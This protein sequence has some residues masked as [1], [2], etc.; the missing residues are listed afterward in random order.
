[1]RLAG[2]LGRLVFVAQAVAAVRVLARMAA[3]ARGVRIETTGVVPVERVSVLVPVLDEEARLPGCLEHLIASE[4]EV[5]EI[6]VVDGGSRDRTSEIAAA[7][8]LRDPRVRY[9]SAAPVADG[10][11]GKAWNLASGL[12]ESDAGSTWILTIDADV[13]IDARLA[14]SLVAHASR[15]GDD[16]MSVATMQQLAGPIDALVHPAFLATLVYRFGLPGV[17][18]HS[19]ASVQANGQCFFGR[20]SALEGSDAFGHARAS[21]CEDVT[22]ARRL[23]A[24]GYAVGFYESAGLATVRMYDDW[25]ALVANWPRSLPMRD[26]YTRTSS[27]VLL[28]EIALVLALPPAIVALFGKTRH[29]REMPLFKLNGILMLIR[30]ATLIGTRRAYCRPAATYWLAPLADFPAVVLLIVSVFRRKH[31]WRGRTLVEAA[32]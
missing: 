30:I 26:R 18:A 8:A 23:F 14:R 2:V 13:R 24:C 29:G 32:G 15:T 1:V 16:A 6:L 31:F 12:V 3:T 11:N 4:A 7:F 19:L 21:R 25:R 28:I 10:W 5:T 9:L 20:R 27:V 17:R 22:A